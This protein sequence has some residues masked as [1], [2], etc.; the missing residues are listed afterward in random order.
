[1]FEVLKIF[2]IGNIGKWGKERMTEGLGKIIKSV[3]QP[4]FDIKF[5]I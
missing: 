1:M 4:P 3:N 2:K 5:Y